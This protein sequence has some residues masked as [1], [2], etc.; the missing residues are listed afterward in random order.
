MTAPDAEAVRRRFAW[1]KDMRQHSRSRALISN[2]YAVGAA[3][4]FALISYGAEPSIAQLQEFETACDGGDEAA[5]DTL[6]QIARDAC[7][8]GDLAGCNFGAPPQDDSLDQGGA[9]D[10]SDSGGPAIENIGLR[11]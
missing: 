4:I 8:S 3:L 11:N 9:H 1:E 6:A 10:P 5:C 7:V 2:H